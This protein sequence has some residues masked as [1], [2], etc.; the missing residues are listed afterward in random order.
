MDRAMLRPSAQD[1]DVFQFILSGPDVDLDKVL[2]SREELI[3]AFYLLTGRTDILFGDLVWMSKYRSERAWLFQL[4]GLTSL[5]H[6]TKHSY[7]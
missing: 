4:L 3:K 5:I 2:T 7:G 1:E 6:E